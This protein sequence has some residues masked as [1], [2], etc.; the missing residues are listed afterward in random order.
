MRS[1]KEN[2][3]KPFDPGIFHI[4]FCHECN[5]MG[6]TLT[7]DKENLEAVCWVC[8][9]SGLFKKKESGLEKM[10]P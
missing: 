9:A 7:G 5:G 10:I 4:N 8:G 6:K 2:T 1:E 3:V